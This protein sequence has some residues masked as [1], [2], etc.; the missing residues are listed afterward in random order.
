MDSIYMGVSEHPDRSGFLSKPS[1][2]S[3]FVRLCRSGGVVVIPLLGALAECSIAWLLVQ[4]P[5]PT[6]SAVRERV[7][8]D[9]IGV[10][11]LLG[12]L[13]RFLVIERNPFAAIAHGSTTTTSRWNVG[14]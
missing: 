10:G 12:V 6:G 4:D 9:P 8:N 5:G 14:V 3:G 2:E 13:L 11:S 1:G 7:L